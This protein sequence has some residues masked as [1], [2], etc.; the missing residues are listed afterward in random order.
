MASNFRDLELKNALS[1]LL[2]LLK[3]ERVKKTEIYDNVSNTSTMKSK[4]EYLEKEKLIKMERFKFDNNTTFVEL[5][6]KG[7]K[8]AILMQ[9]AEEIM[10]G[11]VVFS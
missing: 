11:E 9:Q 4:L 3:A 10:S 8:I 6:D 2:Y 7:R 5:T 1:V